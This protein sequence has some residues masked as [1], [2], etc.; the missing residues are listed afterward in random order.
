[1]KKFAAALVVT[2]LAFTGAAKAATLDVTLGNA[3]NSFTYS[4]SATSSAAN[5]VLSSPGNVTFN[6]DALLVSAPPYSV[7]NQYQEPSVATLYGGNYLA[8]QGTQSNH[9]LATFTLN[10]GADEF[11]FT[12]GTIDTYNTLTLTDSTG[13]TFT[14]TGTAILNQLGIPLSQSGA[15]GSQTDIAFSDAFGNITKATFGTTQNSFEVANFYQG[16]P[17]PTPLP[18]SMVLFITA[19][20]GLGF[21]GYTSRQ[22]K[23]YISPTD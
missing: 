13:H 21:I 12:W 16:D 3:N 17:A 1:M 6:N 11:Q 8:V 22:Q 4:S 2:L 20:L 14:L 5:T 23:I 19:L 15:G 10:S 7:T 18:P 9:G